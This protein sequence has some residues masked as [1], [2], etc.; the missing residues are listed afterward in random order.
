VS[1]T[2]Q[3]QVCANADQ[4]LYKSAS[5][6]AVMRALASFADDDGERCFPSLATLA[7]R[8]QCSKRTVTSVLKEF[9]ERKWIAITYT[10]RSN[11]YRI[12]EHGCVQ[13]GQ[14]SMPS[15][16][17]VTIATQSGNICHS[18][19]QHSLVRDAT[20]ATNSY[21]VTTSNNSDKNI[22]LSRAHEG[23]V[24]IFEEE[25]EV[26]EGKVLEN[27]P[28][29]K[30]EEPRGDSSVTLKKKPSGELPRSP[31][32]TRGRHP[33]QIAGQCSES[34][35]QCCVCGEEHPLG[36]PSLEAICLQLEE[37][38]PEVR[39]GTE[40][41]RLE[42]WRLEQDAWALHDNWLASGF[43]FNSQPIRDWHAAL[44]NWLRYS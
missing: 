42:R 27:A 13:N 29:L 5:Q 19:T 43:R 6:F 40:Q 32:A 41:W 30:A 38:Y 8:S 15:K 12:L 25:E 9:K 24:V 14:A 36:M 10:G 34:T 18:Q 20:V 2:L 3:N 33:A 35:K 1:W 28:P 16:P 39:P 17:E 7:A 23:V 11:R 21:Q 4:G 31:S 44:R 22:E 37:I 26:T